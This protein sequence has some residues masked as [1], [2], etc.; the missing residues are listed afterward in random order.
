MKV[1][2]L[3]HEFYPEYYA[4]TE[5]FVK[6]LAT[7]IQKS[8]N[9]VKIMT[10][11][12][13]KDSFYDQNM[14]SIEFKEFIYEGIPVLA[15][16][17]KERYF[18]TIDKEK[19]VHQALENR[20]LSKVASSLIRREKPDVVHVGHPMRVCELIRVLQPLNIPYV[21]TLT[22]FFL[23]CPKYTLSTSKNTLCTG[24]EGGR[25]CQDLCPEFS[26]HFITRRLETA[27]DILFNARLVV[28]PSSFL[29]GIFEKEFPDLNVK[30]I[31]HGLRYSTLERNNRSY[32]KGDRIVFCYAGS[33][34][35]HKGVHILID[36]FKKVSSND[37]FLSIYGSGA[38]QSYVSDLMDMAKEDRRIEFCG[39]YSED[40]VGEILSKLDVVITPSLWYE[41]Y[42][43]FL[44]EALTCNVPVIASNAGGMAERIK[45]GT[46]GFLFRM[47]DSEHLKEVLQ[48]VTDNP[49]ILNNLKQNISSMMIPTVEQEAYIYERIYKQV[50][51]PK[52]V[53]M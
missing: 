31:N 44:H 35:H 41:N 52:Y 51:D 19:H 3:I 29:A 34:N 12:F 23:I 14:G 53:S 21:I 43:L 6:N 20:E 32:A 46:N 24:P 30:I 47:G 10:Y 49:A 40:R 9:K 2:Y 48:M 38:H 27:R 39:V 5:K 18:D 15:L 13:Y 11:S 26:N 7:M 8:G 37:A 45:D 22:D 50:R 42:P 33:L 4:G 25:A 28:S 16:R 36:A 17:H 1:L